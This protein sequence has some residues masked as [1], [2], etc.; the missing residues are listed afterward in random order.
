MADDR[1]LS[2]LMSFDEAVTAIFIIMIL[3]TTT[4]VMLAQVF[5]SG[6]RSSR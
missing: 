5:G 1:Q 4:V 6:G 3:I 2:F